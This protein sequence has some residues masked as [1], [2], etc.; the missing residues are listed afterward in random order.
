MLY[1]DFGL[2]EP[3]FR[4]WGKHCLELYLNLNEHEF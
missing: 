2:L 1:Y 3:R 4:K